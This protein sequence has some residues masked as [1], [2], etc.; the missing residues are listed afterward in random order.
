[1][2]TERDEKKGL[3]SRNKKAKDEERKTEWIDEWGLGREG[4]GGVGFE[5]TEGER[6]A[7]HCATT[8]GTGR[9]TLRHIHAFTHADTG[10][11]ACACFCPL[12]LHSDPSLASWRADPRS[13]PVLAISQTATSTKEKRAFSSNSTRHHL[14]F[15][16]TCEPH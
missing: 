16:V 9:H 12:P 5:E 15:K 7:G 1:M 13:S 6:T 3:T 14:C 11:L 10:A 2:E 8:P 4:W